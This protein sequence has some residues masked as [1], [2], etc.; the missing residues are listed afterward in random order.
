MRRHFESVGFGLLALVLVLWNPPVRADDAEPAGYREAV[1]QALAEYALGNHEEAST[2]FARAHAIFPNARTLRG[3]GMAAFELRRYAECV[4]QL[5]AALA[6]TVRPLEGELR[7]DTEALLTRARGFV[8]SVQ[9][10]LT[11]ADATLTLDGQPVALVNHGVLVPLGEHVL[12]ARADGFGSQRKPVRVR[13]GEVIRV[14]FVLSSQLIASAPVAHERPLYASPWLW[15]GVGVVV[16]GA[17]ATGVL[18]ARRDRGDTEV[19][20]TSTPN[21]V[22]GVVLTTLGVR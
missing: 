9:V 11:P 16:A 10:Q 14:D 2:L 13:G 4:T 20:P 3:L 22:T 18:L 17:V 19:V 1:E 12:E 5:E 21:A 7:D 6:S 15:T 8:A